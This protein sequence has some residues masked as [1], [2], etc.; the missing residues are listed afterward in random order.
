MPLPFFFFFFVKQQLADPRRCFADPTT[1][2]MAQH[3]P[4]T[5]HICTLCS[6]LLRAT[7]RRQ[8]PNGTTALHR[9]C[10][11]YS[12]VEFGKDLECSNLTGNS[13]FISRQS[14]VPEVKYPLH[15]SVLQISTITGIPTSLYSLKI[16][17]FNITITAIVDFSVSYWQE[18]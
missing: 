11:S 6:M 14:F 16:I 3:R 10:Y 8:S 7:S 4:S 5:Q 15:S 18:R 1:P 17:P 13:A 2:T 12:S 9:A